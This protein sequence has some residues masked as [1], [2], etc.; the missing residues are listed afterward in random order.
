[1][2]EPHAQDAGGPAPKTF[3]DG[4][5]DGAWRLCIESFEG[6]GGGGGERSR[7]GCK[8]RQDA[9]ASFKKVQLS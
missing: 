4:L 9:I 3:E 5:L 1:M 8:Y 2:F 7:V 6:R